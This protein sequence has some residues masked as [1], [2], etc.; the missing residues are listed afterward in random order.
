MFIRKIRIIDEIVD[1]ENDC[2]DLCVESENGYSFTVSVATTKFLLEKMRKRNKNFVEPDDL[3]ILVRKLTEEIIT[4]ALYAYA[5]NDGFW[6]K[7]HHFANE[8]DISVFDKLQ[9]ESRKES[10]EFNLL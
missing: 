2:V 3:V 7:L 10:I 1:I 5:E 8:I 9:E 6:L 4:E